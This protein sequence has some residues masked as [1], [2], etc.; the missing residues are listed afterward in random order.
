M[1][2]KFGRGSGM[3]QRMGLR[4]AGVVAGFVILA[5]IVVGV[6]VLGGSGSTADGPP[7]SKAS[8]GSTSSPS[9]SKAGPSVS[10]TIPVPK[11]SA[12]QLA[13]LPKATTFGKIAGL[14]VSATA[15][16]D[17]NVVRVARDQPGFAT[18]GGQ[19]KTLIPSTQL[20]L[21]TWLPIVDRR[22]GWI[23]VRLP[24]RP[25]GSLAW[26]P[27]SGARTAQTNWRVQISL[28]RGT[29]SIMQGVVRKGTWTVGHGKSADP[30]PT[31]QTFLLAGFVDPTQKFSPVIYALGAHSE[32]LDSFGGGPGTVAVHGWP[33]ADGRRGQVSHGCVRVPS[34]A[35]A[36]FAKL[37]TGTPVDITAS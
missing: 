22:S 29:M 23:Q 3:A 32:T 20:G 34:A 6:K 24:S 16:S 18:P 17:G 5:L 15:N 14:P 19:A 25:N 35:L 11:L 13:A 36:M 37:P 26:I 8:S 28:A 2:G 10:P 21:D 31:G 1:A 4:V 33:T 30:T 9:S 27:A 12:A 7:T